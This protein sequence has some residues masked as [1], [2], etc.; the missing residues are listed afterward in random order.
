MGPGDTPAWTLTR[1][2]RQA[3]VIAV[4]MCSSLGLYLTILKWRGP[5][6]HDHVTYIPAV[7]DWFP[8]EP[9]WVWAYLIPYLVGPIVVG[10]LSR[11]TFAWFVR[12]GLIL[13]GVTL[14]IFIVY[15]TQTKE[16][17]HAD[18]GDNPTARLYKGMIEID[19]PP[20]NA[21][22]SLHVSLTCL[23]ALAIVRDYPRWWLLS[24]GA[25]VLVW[26]ATLFTRQH[27]VIDVLTGTVLA[28]VIALPWRKMTR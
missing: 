9:A 22:P 14:A 21:A 6:G 20:A 15:P 2:V 23:L 25:A 8:F 10:S 27:H 4:I 26:L 5:A 16:R 7:D 11:E 17:A 3:A 28:C 24:F 1:G 13:I 12:R 19:D 18:L